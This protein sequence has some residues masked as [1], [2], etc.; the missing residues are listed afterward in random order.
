MYIVPAEKG[1]LRRGLTILIMEPP[2]K[3]I[4]LESGSD[5]RYGEHLPLRESLPLRRFYPKNMTLID[6]T[7]DMHAGLSGATMQCRM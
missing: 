5:K 1:S 6:R 3:T 2:A 4:S 7:A